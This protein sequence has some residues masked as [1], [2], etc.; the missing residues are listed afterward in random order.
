MALTRE[1]LV[2][3]VTATDGVYWHPVAAYRR[4]RPGHPRTEPFDPGAGLQ[5]SR[6]L[7]NVRTRAAEEAALF[8]VRSAQSAGREP[9]INC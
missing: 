5:A 6:L 9:R 2:P 7:P 3:E 8:R 1:S 4:A